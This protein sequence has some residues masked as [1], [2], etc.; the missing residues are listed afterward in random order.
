MAD[1]LQDRIRRAIERHGARRVAAALGLSAEATCR[2]GGGLP[3]HAGTRALAT[4]N[5]TNLDSLDGPPSR[6]A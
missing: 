6:A 4:A 3:T 2:L 1:E 5:A